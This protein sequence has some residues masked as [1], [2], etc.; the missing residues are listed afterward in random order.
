MN[1]Y[2]LA[3]SYYNLFKITGD[4]RY[5]EGVIEL[6][7]E[8]STINETYLLYRTYLDLEEYELANQIYMNMPPEYREF[9]SSIIIEDDVER[10]QSL[11]SLLDK[12]I[13]IL[14]YYVYLI[15]TI[16]QV[17][18]GD[19]LD[20]VKEAAM[21]NLKDEEKEWMSS[22]LDIIYAFRDQHDGRV[23]EL[24]IDENLNILNVSEYI[25]DS[26]NMVLMSI[27]AYK[28]SQT[29]KIFLAKHKPLYEISL[30]L[31]YSLG[32]IDERIYRMLID[33]EF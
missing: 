1:D 2:K 3:K 16:V 31:L 23:L 30:E 11:Y 20:N 15:N 12:G 14:D 13:E 4:K 32:K 19:L 8:P 22:F 9:I 28:A 24:I 33:A 17:G 10:L 5:L 18:R 29:Y 7:S 27:N 6:L 26:W 21:K 25:Y